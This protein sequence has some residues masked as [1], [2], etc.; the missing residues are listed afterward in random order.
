RSTLNAQ[1]STLKPQRSLRL[2]REPLDVARAASEGAVRIVLPAA[3]LRAPVAVHQVEAHGVA[4]IAVVQWVVR[5]V[6]P[7]PG[8]GDLVPLFVHGR[9]SG[10][11]PAVQDQDRLRGTRDAGEWR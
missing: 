8:P 11:G 10:C 3:P 5:G 4:R 2:S 7:A 1:R 9:L 6:A